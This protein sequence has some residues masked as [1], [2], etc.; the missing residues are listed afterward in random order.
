MAI[1][2]VKKT[3]ELKHKNK[4]YIF[5]YPTLYLKNI[6]PVQ[7]FMGFHGYNLEHSLICLFH[8]S[9]AD[10]KAIEEKCSNHKQFDFA[11]VDGEYLYIV[12]T[13]MWKREFYNLIKT[14]QYSKVQGSD[15]AL[16]M[17]GK[18]K[19]YVDMALTPQS[20]YSEFAEQFQCSAESLAAKGAELVSPPDVNSE[21]IT[22]SKTVHK[23]LQE[24]LELVCTS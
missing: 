17:W 13:F 4:S 18:D 8:T 12:F 9:Q 5:L 21:Y 15:R 16:I 23:H 24:D 3:L 19:E 20:Y 7:T 1:D 11:V 22:V 10:M 14:G 2:L 6:Y